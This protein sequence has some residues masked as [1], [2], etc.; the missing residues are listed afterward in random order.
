MGGCLYGIRINVSHDKEKQRQ[1][2]SLFRNTEIGKDAIYPNVGLKIQEGYEGILI[3]LNSAVI[4]N[5]YPFKFEQHISV[6]HNVEGLPF[7]KLINA[8]Q[9]L[10]DKCEHQVL[11]ETKNE[12]K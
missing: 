3:S 10:K 11:M 8:I 5:K 1:N 12:K 9:S 7:D 2:M 6:N 4:I